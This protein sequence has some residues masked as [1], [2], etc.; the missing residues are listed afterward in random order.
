MDVPALLAA[1]IRIPTVAPDG[2]F[3][4]FH[5]FLSDAFPALFSTAVRRDFGDAILLEL[6]GSDTAAAP[7][8]LMAHQDVV[9]IEEDQPWSH[10]PFAGVV[11]DGYV[12]GRGAL[13]DK[14]ALITICAA[15]EGL[16]GEGWRPTRTVFL[17]FGADEE[18]SG[19]TAKAAAAH[20]L[21][22]GVEPWFVLDEGGAIVTEAL[23]TVSGRVA[24]IGATEKGSLDVRL[25]A[26]SEGGHAST[27]PTFG[28]PQRI[29]QA[30]LRLQRRPFPASLDDLSL[31]MFEA[32][33]PRTSGPLATLFRNARRLRVPLARGMARFSPE[34]AAL[35]RTTVAVTQLDGSPAANVLAASATA[36]LNIRIAAGETVASV[37][38]QLRR[39]IRDNKVEILVVDGEDPSP[40]S[41]TGADP[42]W[43]AITDT[44]TEVFPDVI[45]APYQ[46]LAASDGRHFHRAFPRVYRFAPLDM[47][48]ELRATVHG[49]DERVAVESVKRAVIFW[50]RLLEVAK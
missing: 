44:V 40:I 1:A 30:I 28:A 49:T 15:I 47:S 50:R 48:A 22:R 43:R 34:S 2:D 8:I 42:A 31:E 10:P 17:S 7:I 13:D 21:E 32:L 6:V 27:P 18:L 36:N 3:D 12:W 45:V 14:G 29:A 24:M 11:A 9:P 33:T 23:P 37:V 16:L 41:P 25:T 46:M 19:T 38:H 39:V 4:A 5:E 26:R 20:L 35:V